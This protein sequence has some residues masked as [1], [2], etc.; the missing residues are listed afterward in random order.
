[1]ST[2]IYDAYRFPSEKLNEFLAHVRSRMLEG[3]FKKIERLMVFGCTREELDAINEK[4]ACS[5]YLKDA[6]PERIGVAKK[7]HRWYMLQSKLKAASVS[8]EKST[9]NVDASWNLWIHDKWIYAI[10]YGQYKHGAKELDFVEDFSFWNNTDAPD[11]VPEE[12]FWA[13]GDV[14]EE[15]CL[16][17]WNGTRL[18]HVVVDFSNPSPYAAMLAERKLF[19][20]EI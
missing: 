5:D 1:M 10:P 16:N 4:I 9:Y 7:H 15:V 18:N 6:T 3:F 14:W 8:S 20:Q 12:E 11:D 17:D 13:R 19:R 2:K